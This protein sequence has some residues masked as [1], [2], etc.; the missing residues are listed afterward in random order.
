[1][2]GL[3]LPFVVV[4]ATSGCSNL[5]A[6]GCEHEFRDPVV[7]VRSVQDSV[8]GSSISRLA[9]ND[10]QVDGRPMPAQYLVSEPTASRVAVLG[11]TLWCQVTCGFGTAE[12]VWRLRVSAPGYAPAQLSVT[13]RYARGGGNCPSYSAGSTLLPVRLAPGP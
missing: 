11:D 12:G 13:A 10:L 8:R 2:R 3:A 4:S 9:I 6:G 1:M 7:V 5:G